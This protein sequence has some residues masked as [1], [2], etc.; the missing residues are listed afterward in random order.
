MHIVHCTRV[1]DIVPISLF[2]R[3]FVQVSVLFSRYEAKYTQTR[4]VRVQT[5]SQQQQG[6]LFAVWCFA[7]G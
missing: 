5:Y 2:I 4:G 7:N 6:V 1:P 3:V